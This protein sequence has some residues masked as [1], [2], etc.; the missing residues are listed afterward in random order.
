MEEDRE[1]EEYTP[2][3]FV[4]EEQEEG[5][6]IH[7]ES[8]E[9][10]TLLSEEEED[11]IEEYNDSLVE[12][13]PIDT[14]QKH[15]VSEDDIE[16]TH[17]QSDHKEE[18]RDDDSF[19]VAIEDKVTSEFFKKMIQEEHP[20]VEHIVY[21]NLRKS[22][23]IHSSHYVGIGEVLFKRDF[24]PTI[25][26]S[27]RAALYYTEHLDILVGSAKP[28]GI[29]FTDF[30]EYHTRF[31]LLP[32]S[33]LEELSIFLGMMIFHARVRKIIEQGGVTGLRTIFG[34][35]AADFGVRR[36]PLFLHDVDSLYNMFKLPNHWDIEDLVRE[37]GRYGLGLC[38]STL[39]KIL[40]KS[41]M[42]KLPRG[43][44][45]SDEYDPN[46]VG[47]EEFSTVQRKVLSNKLFP[48]LRKILTLEV[49]PEWTPFFF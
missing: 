8:S 9:E 43:F 13:A 19:D 14:P 10:E 48:V 30:S 45:S 38:V 27:R 46:A 44:L 22:N 39:P 34:K 24:L 6:F 36:V 25:L 40:Q 16:T 4:E 41:I 20:I 29:W 49:A 5:Y 26:S 32:G 37:S 11:V 18:S 7:D 28:K 17:I 2:T 42:L 21:F 47:P 3:G 15:F 35:K 31:A 1:E 23:E 12:D 33:I